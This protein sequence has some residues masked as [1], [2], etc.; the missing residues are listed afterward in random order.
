MQSLS[1]CG[2]LCASKVVLAPDKRKALESTMSLVTQT[3]ASVAC[4][5]GVA[6]RHV[7][8]L[9]EVQSLMLQKEEV[10]V[11][12]VSQLLDIH[13]EKVSRQK[14][15]K[16]T[17]A[18]KFQHTQ[19]IQSGQ[20]R[21]LGSY[22]RM[23]INFTSLDNTGH[24]ILDSDLQLSKTGTMS[25]KI[26]VKTMSQ[27]LGRSRSRE[28]VSPPSIPAQKVPCPIFHDPSRMN[29]DLPL[30][31]PE[32]PA[33]LA[34]ETQRPLEKGSCFPD[35]YTLMCSDLPPPPEPEVNGS[36]LLPAPIMEDL[37][38]ESL[39]PPPPAID[40]DD[41]HSS[42][43][44]ENGLTSP[45]C[46]ELSADDLPPPPAPDYEVTN[47]VWP[48]NNGL[49]SPGCRELSADDLPPP[50]APDYEVTNTVWPLNNADIMKSPTS[51]DDLPPPSEM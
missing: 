3:L 34:L 50:P 51:L 17:T 21:P 29:G 47:T 43:L 33:P 18:K 44:T 41:K 24:G 40:N 1:G 16:L 15:G 2:I 12:Y 22:T 9:L 4:Q 45:G 26:S 13:A 30:P 23:P 20:D 37:F 27:T 49:T 48:L 25:R 36:L 31:P 38:D 35:Q 10:R 8:D 32:Y 42:W 14:I 28:P 46:R 7:S 5:V 11:R 39:P 19:K 6:A